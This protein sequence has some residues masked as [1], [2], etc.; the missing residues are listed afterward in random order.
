MPTGAAEGNDMP[1]AD[2]STVFELL[3]SARSVQVLGTTY[4]HFALPGGDELYV[5]EH[6]LPFLDCLRPENFW[7]DREWIR[8]HRRRLSGS[9]SIYRI[10][11][12]PCKGR[13]KEIVLKWN[14]MGQD[15]PGET[16]T[17]DLAGAV[18]NSPFE[19]FSLVTEL[20]S[21]ERRGVERVFTHKPLAIYVPGEQV[22]PEL[23]GRKEDRI[24]AMQERHAGVVLHVRRKYAV[25]YEWIKGIDAHEAHMEKLLSREA[26]AALVARMDEAMR[27]RGF[28]VRDNKAQHA[29]VRCGRDGRLLRDRSGSIAFAT[30]DFELLERTPGRER[31]VRQQKRKTYL[32]RQAHRFEDRGAFPPN[33][34]PVSIMGVDYVYGRAESTDGALWVVGKD[35]ALF[36]YFLPEKWRQTPR[37]KL[38]LVSQ[39]YHTTTKDNVHLVW[40]VSRVGELPDMDPSKPEEKQILE[41]GYNSP[42]EEIALNVELNRRGI[43]TTYPRA[44]YRTGGRL[45]MSDRLADPRRFRSHE[46]LRMPDGTPALK[47]NHEYVIIWGYWNGPDE[48]L[49]EKDADYLEAINALQAYRDGLIDEETYIRVVEKVRSALDRVAVEDLNLRGNH[50]LLSLDSAGRL[51][52][53]EIGLPTVRICN[54]ELLRRI[55]STDS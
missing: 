29:I 7:L 8:A 38:S 52:R 49:A 50:I 40:K 1:P 44:I 48:L 53:D 26:L 51:V 5:T 13:Q 36:D 6:G 19:E 32:V 9:S 22:E 55:H 14:R 17:G 25:I 42:F 18:F 41:Y 15:V 10:Q 28:R 12:R 20:R 35:S 33:L 27:R 16:E 46:P 54:F 3:G 11:T 31:L 4:A 21:A 30:V 47:P 2:R 24:A 39:I 34:S 45:E 43:A 37:T 23:L